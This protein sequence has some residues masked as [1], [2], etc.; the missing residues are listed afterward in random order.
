VLVS[1]GL[2]VLYQIQADGAYQLLVVEAVLLL[3]TGLAFAA[4]FRV[5][6]PPTVPV[7]PAVDHELES[8]LREQIMDLTVAKAD[9]EQA[10]LSKAQFL[11]SMAQELRTSINAI[12]NFSQFVS[13]GMLGPITREQVEI[14]MKISSS[15]KNM[16]NLINDVQDLSKMEYGALRLFVEDDIDIHVELLSVIDAGKVILKEKPV[17][18]IVETDEDLPEIVGDRRRLRQIMLNI[19]SNA[20]KFTEQGRIVIRLCRVADEI[21]L[22]VQDTGPGIPSDEREAIF[23]PFRK[24]DVRLGEGAGLGLPMARHLTQAHEGR[25]WLESTVGTGTTFFVALPTYSEKLAALIAI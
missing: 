18:L 11:S 21:V 4:S 2:G 9:A 16:L 6:T 10:N 5:R 13:T 23:E 12:L 24:G 25:L 22:S 3:I 17:E 7:T 19:I 15:G 14:L 8:R 20:C 1:I